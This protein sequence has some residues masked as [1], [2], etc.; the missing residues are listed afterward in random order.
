VDTAGGV[1]QR[2]GLYHLSTTDG[3]SDRRLF[4]PPATPRLL[5]SAPL[6]RVVLTRDEMANMVWGIEDVIPGMAGGGVVGFEAA[7]G[8][9]RYFRAQ[10]DAVSP[11]PPLDT[12]AQI[13]YH[14]G[15]HVPEN[16]IP[17]IAVHAPGSNREIRLQRA[18]LPRLIPGLTPTPVEPRGTILRFGLDEEPSQPYFINEEE[19]PRAGVV[20]T[21]TYQRSRWWDGRIYT[22]LGR[23][24]QTGRGQGSSGLAFDQIDNT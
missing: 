24:K 13:R 19:V 17:F 2:W 8:L 9:E 20:V 22:W 21:S 3:G 4:M 12:G 14:L 5:E 16:W 18:S 6:E 1:R 15:T 7:A 10:A 23:R 11:A